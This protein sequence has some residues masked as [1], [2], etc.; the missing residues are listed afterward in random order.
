[1]KYMEVDSDF[2]R[3]QTKKKRNQKFI[4]DSN[5][6]FFKAGNVMKVTR[7]IESYECK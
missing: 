6:R 2:V 3:M 7:E 1:M 4:S 5:G